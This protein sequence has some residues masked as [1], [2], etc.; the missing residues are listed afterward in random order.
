[1]PS[2]IRTIAKVN[3][4]AVAMLRRFTLST[5]GMKISARGT[6]AERA[7]DAFQPHVGGLA[8]QAELVVQ[9]EPAWKL[10][11]ARPDQRG[12][13][14]VRMARARSRCSGRSCRRR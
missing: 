1:M 13:P 2:P 11:S 3:P 4:C 5:N 6:D 10:S 8:V 9:V 12:W 7:L 14:E